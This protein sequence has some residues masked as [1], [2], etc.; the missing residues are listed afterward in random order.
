V[1]KSQTINLSISQNQANNRHR[2]RIMTGK[3]AETEPSN[4][5]QNASY[6]S[7]YQPH[8]ETQASWQNHKASIYNY[9]STTQRD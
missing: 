9:L 7:T 3:D 4:K 2:N 8:K 5:K 6:Q 1:A